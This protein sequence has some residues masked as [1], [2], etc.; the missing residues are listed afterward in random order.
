V[1]AGGKFFP[2]AALGM[3]H[4]PLEFA[5]GAQ[6]KQS[7]GRAPVPIGELWLT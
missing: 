7:G 3:L 5:A 2:P 4:G 6:L 1:E